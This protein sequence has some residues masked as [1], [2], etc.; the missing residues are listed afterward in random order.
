MQQS[1]DSYLEKKSVEKISLKFYEHVNE[2]FDD[3][4]ED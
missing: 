1:L 2:N 3:E 4:E